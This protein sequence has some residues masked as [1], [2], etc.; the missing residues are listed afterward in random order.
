MN[1]LSGKGWKKQIVPLDEAFEN[2]EPGM[3]IFLGTGGGEPR[4]LVKHIMNSEHP[5]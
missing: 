1:L 5:T 3:S 4:T 2:I